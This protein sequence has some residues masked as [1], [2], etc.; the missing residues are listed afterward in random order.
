M[1]KI[2]K[3][4]SAICWINHAA[5]NGWRESR[6]TWGFYCCF[7]KRDYWLR[8]L[9]FDFGETLSQVF[10]ASLER[11]IYVLDVGELLGRMDNAY[12]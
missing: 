5:R 12:L 8:C 11:T 6:L 4:H 10:Q 3:F 2:S 1:S 9:D 7:T